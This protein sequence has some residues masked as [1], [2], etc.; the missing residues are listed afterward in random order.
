MK[1]GN[2]KKILQLKTISPTTLALCIITILILSA[3]LI[4]FVIFSS[5]PMLIRADSDSDNLRR[6]Q[7]TKNANDIYMMCYEAH[8]SVQK[9]PRLSLQVA[10]EII[11]KNILDIIIGNTGY[12]FVLAGT[13]DRAGH[14]IISQGGEHDGE[15]PWDK[16]D[17][18][19]RSYIQSMVTK[20][21]ASIDGS[22]DFERY[23]RDN[24]ADGGDGAN[25]P[26]YM[27]TAVTYFKPWD[28]VIGASVY[29][30][31]FKN[32]TSQI[33]DIFSGTI[34]RLVIIF[35]SLATLFCLYVIKETF[36]STDEIS[37]LFD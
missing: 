18:A 10:K 34:F 20:A 25:R 24:R 14:Y 29:E 26:R 16:T 7:L 11:R 31:E 19:G 8:H 37:W 2:N 27:I 35:I 15:N 9:Q 12:A 22:V 23:L 32:T 30:D 5:G 21:L 36:F 6:D 28:W 33:T 13:G 1:L 3:S 17:K 4:M